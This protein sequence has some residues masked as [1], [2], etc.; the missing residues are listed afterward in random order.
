MR[1]LSSQRPNIYSELNSITLFS[2]LTR[3]Q[4]DVV[5]NQSRIIELKAGE[6][7][8]YAGENARYFYYLKQGQ[9]RIFLESSEGNEK[10]IDVIHSGQMF[11]EA[12]AFLDQEPY[13]VSAQTLKK[14][15]LYAIDIVAFKSVLKESIETCF[16]V[17]AALTKRLHFQLMEINNLS[18]HNA[19]YRLISHLI[20]QVPESASGDTHFV[21]DYPKNVLASRLSIKPETLSRI[22]LRMKNNQ[23][24]DIES[25]QI[26]L[27]NLEKLKLYLSNSDMF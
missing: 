6:K 11:A 13:P 25:N 20:Q 24:I 8:F 16:R 9:V 15:T 1:H 27:K 5:I 14:S 19:T 18:L 3:E 22:L 26:I 10:V 21:L 12:V 7:L 17:M 23:L 4:L 2:Q